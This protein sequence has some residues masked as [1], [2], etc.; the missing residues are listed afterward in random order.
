MQAIDLPYSSEHKSKT[1]VRVSLQTKTRHKTQRKHLFR[2]M[3]NHNVITGENTA[4]TTTEHYSKE[5]ATL[6]IMF[7]YYKKHTTSRKN[8]NTSV[9]SQWVAAILLAVEKERDA[10]KLP[11]NQ[12]FLR[13]KT[14]ILLVSLQT[15][16]LRFVIVSTNNEIILFYIIILKRK[17]KLNILCYENIF[18]LNYC[19]LYTFIYYLFFFYLDL[20]TLQVLYYLYLPIKK[21]RNSQ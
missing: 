17:T 5:H 6:T 3:F 14:I 8:S 10:F 11:T 21:L 20:L 4:C 13:S 16:K 18:V 1:D 19:K 2:W 15:S 9:V 12:T 7:I